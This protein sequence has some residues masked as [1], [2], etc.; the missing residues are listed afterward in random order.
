MNNLN[1]IHG[2]IIKGSSMVPVCKPYRRFD[3]ECNIEYNDIQIGDIIVFQIGEKI[4]VKYCVAKEYDEVTF[5]DIHLLINNKIL[6][7]FWNG[8]PYKF[9]HPTSKKL[10]SG[11]NKVPK[12]CIF[13]LGARDNTRDT[14]RYG[15]IPFKNI[16]GRLILSSEHIHTQSV[17]KL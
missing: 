3:I 2:V 6:C 1:K 5:N 12:E 16:I 10:M 8:K 4:F 7:K 13:V 11:Y 15:A 9:T 14:T 17:K